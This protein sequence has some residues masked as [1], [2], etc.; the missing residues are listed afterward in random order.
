MGKKPQR[1]G[2]MDMITSL[3][4]ENFGP[5]AHIVWENLDR[6]NLVIGGNN[7]GKTTILKAMYG[8]I[9]AVEKFQVAEDNNTSLAECLATKL[10]G[11]FQPNKLGD[12]VTNDAKKNLS[13]TLGM[14]QK[15]EKTRSSLSYNLSLD[16]TRSLN[17]VSHSLGSREAS[18]IFL[19]SKE[20]LSLHEIVINSRLLDKFSG[21]DDTDLDLARALTAIP[22]QGENPAIF[23]QACA[24]LEEI[25]DG[26]VEYDQE[27][28]E[29]YF[30]Q[31]S[32]KHCIGLTAEGVK[33]IGTF[34]ALLRNRC[35]ALDSIVFVDE[36]ATALHPAMV[37]KFLDIIADL[38]LAEHDQGIQF[39]LASHSYY[40]IKKLYLITQRR[41]ISIPIL[42]EEG[43]Q[44]Q[45]GDLR[46]G[47]PT[48]SII[49]ESIRLY[50]EEMDMLL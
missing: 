10:Q 46:D 49:D 7:A 50:E 16:A 11:V 4:L 48:N 6:I 15:R 8:A 29:W 19:P 27:T 21:F 28:R 44:W 47:M 18:S 34:D 40:V 43:G 36:P 31:G 41:K 2:V 9:R 22:P 42:Y 25:I 24:A 35:L 37:V 33:K 45:H 23:A 13:C 12:L 32:I 1:G 39:F 38:A 20:I 3:Q 30:Q 14:A 5:V 26:K 17:S